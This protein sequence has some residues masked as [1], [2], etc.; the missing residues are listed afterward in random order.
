MLVES[1]LLIIRTSEYSKD[2]KAKKRKT[3]TGQAVSHT[4]A[5]AIPIAASSQ[6]SGPPEPK[7]DR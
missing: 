5:P 6:A 7:K 4:P 3:S 1:V 2:K